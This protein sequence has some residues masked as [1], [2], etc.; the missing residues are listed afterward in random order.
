MY[1]A[2]TPELPHRTAA[3]NTF[4]IPL[5]LEPIFPSREIA[6]SRNHSMAATRRVFY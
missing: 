3:I 1:C 4:N 2:Q 6:Q 5:L